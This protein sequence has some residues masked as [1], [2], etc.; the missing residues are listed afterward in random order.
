ME[1][2]RVNPDHFEDLLPFSLA[3]VV[4]IN[5]NFFHT[6]AR[7]HTYDLLTYFIYF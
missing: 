1:L 5:F 7:H 4:N 3:S 6:H 2:V